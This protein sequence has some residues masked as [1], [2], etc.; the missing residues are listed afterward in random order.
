M[1]EQWTWSQLG[2]HA[3][4]CGF[5]N[6]N[7]Y[8]NELLAMISRM[9]AEGFMASQFAAMLTADTDTESLLARFRTYHAPTQ[10]WAAEN[11]PLEQLSDRLRASNVSR[12]RIATAVLMDQEGR[13]LLVRK[14]SA[15]FF[16]QPGGKLEEGE[17]ALDALARELTEELGCPLLN[18]SLGVFTADAANEPGET[19]EATVFRVEINGEVR[20]RAE[21]E[22]LVWIYPTDCTVRVAPLTRLHILPLIASWG[23]K[24]PDLH[25]ADLSSADDSF[26][27]IRREDT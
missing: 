4:P 2:I 16:M 23:L 12:I 8:F 20:P 9:M 10:K 1:F 15:R 26:L 3:K 6:V 18:Y 17:T 14:R 22:E 27:E 7:G 5:L 13:V 19:V 24:G 11:T 25:A 21:I